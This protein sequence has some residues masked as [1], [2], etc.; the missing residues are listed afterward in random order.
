MR[1]TCKADSDARNLLFT[2]HGHESP[3]RGLTSDSTG[4]ERESFSKGPIYSLRNG[5]NSLP[6]DSLAAAVDDDL[7]PLAALAADAR[8]GEAGKRREPHRVSNTFC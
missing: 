3:I 5:S 4:P 2:R 1:R 7:P 6:R 8:S